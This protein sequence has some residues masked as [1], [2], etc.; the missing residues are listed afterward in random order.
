MKRSEVNLACQRALD[1]FNQHGWFLPPEPAWDVTD[2]GMGDFERDG[3]VLVNLAL[4]PEYS[5]KLIY[6]RK[7]QIV[8]FHTHVRK[9]EDIICRW[10]H[11]VVEVWPGKPGEKKSDTVRIK[12]NGRETSWPS[13]EQKVLTAGERVTLVPGMYHSFWS[14]DE[15][16]IV[17]EVSTANDDQGDNIYINPKIS[18]FSGI[19][20]DV[21]AKF[22]IVS[23]TA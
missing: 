20:E 23:E 22:R 6:L 9:K 11:L 15:E 3:L 14:R 16:C 2:H 5:E 21:P 13:G 17:G 1:C 18:R 19:V 8:P 7:G 4:E 12:Q 10:G